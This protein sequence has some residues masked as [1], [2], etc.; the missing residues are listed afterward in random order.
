MAGT[1]C[2]VLC[3]VLAVALASPDQRVMAEMRVAADPIGET[4]ARY[5]SWTIDSSYNR[6]SACHPP[7]ICCTFEH[8]ALFVGSQSYACCASA[9]GIQQGVQHL[10]LHLHARTRSLLQ[11]TAAP[12]PAP[13]RKN[14]LITCST[15]TCTCT[16]ELAHY[17]RA[18]STCTC[19]QELARS[20][21]NSLKHL[22]AHSL[23]HPLTRPHPHYQLTRHALL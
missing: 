20:L 9:A 10:H 4:N 7:H 13:A 15:C 21:T 3:A 18:C 8:A 12:A 16:Q 19:T 5:A 11:G 1:V 6:W 17:C 2:A 22:L 14:S 23:T